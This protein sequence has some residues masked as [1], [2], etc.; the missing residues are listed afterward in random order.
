MPRP[1]AADTNNRGYDSRRFSQRLVVSQQR[2]SHRATLMAVSLVLYSVF[3]FGSDNDAKP[4]YSD[5]F[6]RL[7]GCIMTKD[8]GCPYTRLHNLS[9]ECVSISH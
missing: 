9:D 6:F 2:K 8:V 5:C 7:Q 3:R 1:G 4:L